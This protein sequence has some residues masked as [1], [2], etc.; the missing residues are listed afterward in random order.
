MA[1]RQEE[2]DKPPW[3]TREVIDDNISPDHMAFQDDMAHI[4]DMLQDPMDD[5]T[6]DYA[7]QFVGGVARSAH[8]D[9]LET[10]ALALAKARAKGTSARSETATLAG[11]V[12]QRLSR[13]MAI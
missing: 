1:R 9:I 11:L 7:A 8:D 6:L 13:K 2:T 3:H 5:G 12:Q 4:A 10:A